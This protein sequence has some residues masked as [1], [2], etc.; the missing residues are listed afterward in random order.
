MMGVWLDIGKAEVEPLR[1]SIS[2]RKA[3][4]V[5]RKLEG[6]ATEWIAKKDVPLG[7]KEE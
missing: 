2:Y 1:W 7:K 4:G 6:R 3:K 5:R